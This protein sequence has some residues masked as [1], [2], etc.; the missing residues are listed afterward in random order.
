MWIMENGK[1][2]KV[3]YEDGKWVRDKVLVFQGFQDDFLV[4]FNPSKKIREIIH[5]SRVIRI[6][7]VKHEG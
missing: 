6:E 3:I 1:T 5:K 2:Y 7:E 4:F